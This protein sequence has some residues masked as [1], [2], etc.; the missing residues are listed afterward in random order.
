MIDKNN[1]LIVKVYYQ[2]CWLRQLPVGQS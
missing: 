2:S 1:A